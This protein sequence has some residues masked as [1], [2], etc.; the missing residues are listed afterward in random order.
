MKLGDFRYDIDQ[1]SFFDQGEYVA[2]VC[3]FWLDY[4]LVKLDVIHIVSKE[5]SVLN[6]LNLV[7]IKKSFS[8]Q[9][10]EFDE[11]N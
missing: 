6:V 3:W 5:L 8:V 7:I 1:V 10:L 4:Q 2:N 9:R 11:T